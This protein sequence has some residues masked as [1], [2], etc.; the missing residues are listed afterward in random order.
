MGRGFACSV[1]MASST[2]R[3][4]G[5]APAGWLPRGPGTGPAWIAGFLRSLGSAPRSP[6]CGYCMGRTPSPSWEVASADP[7]AG[8]LDVTS[9]GTRPAHLVGL[10]SVE[11]LPTTRRPRRPASRP[12]AV[13]QSC[14]CRRR[15]AAIKRVWLPSGSAARV[16][17]TLRRNRHDRRRR[18][19]HRWTGVFPDRA[20]AEATHAHHNLPFRRLGRC[21]EFTRP[22]LLALQ[23]SQALLLQAPGG[24]PVQVCRTPASAAVRTVARNIL[25]WPRLVRLSRV[26]GFGDPAAVLVV[27][28]RGSLAAIALCRGGIS[29]LP[30]PGRAVR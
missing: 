19:V 23:S 29:W 4:L 8:S 27:S 25:N 9:V 21:Y 17:R 6:E 26:A 13:P 10:F 2:A 18:R 22:H 7:N 3:P 12:C 16:L 1:A 30:S 11:V 14:A 5:A 24:H 20:Q 15:A 28:G